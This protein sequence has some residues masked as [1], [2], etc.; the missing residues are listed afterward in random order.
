MAS[1]EQKKPNLEI[2]AAA[3]SQKEFMSVK[4]RNYDAML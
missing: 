1:D 2:S 4:L 3:K